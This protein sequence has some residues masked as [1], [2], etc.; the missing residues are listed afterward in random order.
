MKILI[1]SS[2]DEFDYDRKVNQD[3]EIDLAELIFDL[4]VFEND[5]GKRQTKISLEKTYQ[6]IV[7]DIFYYDT[8][9]ERP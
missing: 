4:Y 8:K 5:V 9:G 2:C 7:A 3:I 6:K 1:G